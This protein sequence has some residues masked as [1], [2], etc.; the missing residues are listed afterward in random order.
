MLQRRSAGRISR[1]SKRHHPNFKTIEETSP[2]FTAL[3]IDMNSVFE[4]ELLS[5]WVPK[6]T[7][8]VYDVVTDSSTSVS[9]DGSLTPPVSRLSGGISVS[10]F[11]TRSK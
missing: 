9:T 7:E 10:S 1:Q 4:F 11:V 2:E 3:M 8:A 6:E 5:R